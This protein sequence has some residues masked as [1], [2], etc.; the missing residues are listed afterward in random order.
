MGVKG[1]FTIIST[2]ANGSIETKHMS[3]YRGTTQAIDASLILYK[4]CL[5]GGNSNCHLDTCLH[6]TCTMLK[7]GIM[8]A[9]IFDGKSP[10][11]K[12]HTINKRKKVREDAQEK[13]TDPNLTE[14][15][16]IK[17]L[18][19]ATALTRTNIDDVKKLL[20]LMGIVYIESAEEA[21][22][23]CAEL[24]INNVVDGVVSEDWD[25]LLFGCEKMLKNFFNKTQV[26]EINVKNLLKELDMN[27]EQ[28][29]DLSAI[30]G[31]DYCPGVIGLKPVEAFA[32]F[33]ECN[34]DME[35]FLRVTIE[36]NS[37]FVPINFTQLWLESKKYY[38]E[39]KY[40][41]ETNHD[42]IT[43]S[44]PDYDNLYK[45]LVFEKQF[46]KEIVINKINELKKMYTFYMD[47]GKKLGPYNVIRRLKP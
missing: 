44:Q 17:Y 35:T 31:N 21:D 16:K 36:Q 12:L 20:R 15:E 3:E 43:W 9:W 33:K 4:Y 41:T 29:I 46:S 13:L 7:Y 26:V 1:L 47:K 14:E 5:F 38:M 2:F 39:N 6:K 37:C 18:K 40:I 8:P 10:D 28:L 32:K 24:N 23:Q 11:I 25:L 19:L 45:Y 42:K 34:S 27:L 30:L 22:I